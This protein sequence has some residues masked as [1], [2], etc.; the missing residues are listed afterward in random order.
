M[1]LICDVALGSTKEFSAPRA[2]RGCPTGYQSV[3]GLGIAPGR[4]TEFEDNEYVVFDPS[5]IRV[6]YLVEFTA[7]GET[8]IIPTIVPKS[9]PPPPPPIVAAEPEITDVESPLS[10]AIDETVLSFFFL[11]LFLSFFSFIFF[12]F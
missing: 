4:V 8:A 9:A 12:L 5:Q 3:L 10:L 7:F 11:F 6:K 1:M 2:E